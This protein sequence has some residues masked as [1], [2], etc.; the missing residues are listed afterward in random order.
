VQGSSSAIMKHI[1]SPY[2]FGGTEQNR[3]NVVNVTAEI[4]KRHFRN[5]SR[6]LLWSVSEPWRRRM[7][8]IKI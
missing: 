4:S 2:L 7:S 1:E 3:Q 6:M 5:A 8:K